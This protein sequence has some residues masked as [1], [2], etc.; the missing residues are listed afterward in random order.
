MT[1]PSLR[2]ITDIVGEINDSPFV[3]HGTGWVEPD[4]TTSATLTF[5]RP[6]LGY[7]P[8][9]GKSWK[10]SHHLRQALPD[11]HPL[12]EYVTAGGHIMSRA[13]IKY[14]YPDSVIL[15]TSLLRRPNPSL[16]HVYQTRVGTFTG[17]T[18]IV[19]Q[20]PYIIHIDPTGVGRAVSHSVRQVRRGT[21]EI[22][23]VNYIEDLYFADN[24][25]L[26]EPI[27]IEIAGAARYDP[28]RLV[29][30]LKTTARATVM[31]LSG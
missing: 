24:F 3:C 9:Y 18:D 8:M 10:C 21:G 28:V 14:P 26:P 13:V 7:T 15:V 29:Y 1:H 31:T 6:L 30:Y 19:E 22:I 23:D 12:A 25:I 2:L 5:D 16:Q 27:T 4:G 20:L 17:P 11:N